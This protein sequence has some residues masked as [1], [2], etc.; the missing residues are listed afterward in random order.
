MPHITLYAPFSDVAVSLKKSAN[1]FRAGFPEARTRVSGFQNAR[2]KQPLQAAWFEFLS[3][4]LL[5]FLPSVTVLHIVFADDHM[6]FFI[7]QRG[8]T[9]G[10]P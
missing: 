2:K 5:F 3:L 10:I 7:Q 8:N 4:M 9:A 6:S 1:L